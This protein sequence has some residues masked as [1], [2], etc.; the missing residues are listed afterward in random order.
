VKTAAGIIT[1]ADRARFKGALGFVDTSLGKMVGEL[2][3]RGLRESTLIVV[4]AKPGQSPID[5]TKLAMESGGNGDATVKDPLPF[6]DTGDPVIGNRPTSMA[7]SA[8]SGPHPTPASLQ[9]G[10]D[11]DAR[12]PPARG[13]NARSGFL[14]GL[15]TTPSCASSA[16]MAQP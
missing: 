8:G 10:D 4:T 2:G 13:L 6:V 12:Q 15:L 3:R 14:A 9:G 16:S 1:T 5:K 11:A 7:C